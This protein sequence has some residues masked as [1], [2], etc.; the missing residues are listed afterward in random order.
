MKDDGKPKKNQTTKQLVMDSKY[1]FLFFFLIM[2]DSVF[3]SGGDVVDIIHHQI[4]T[5]LLVNVFFGVLRV[6]LVE[7]FVLNDKFQFIDPDLFSDDHGHEPTQSVPELV[8]NV[9]VDNVL[10][11]ITRKRR[12]ID[13]RNWKY[14]IIPIRTVNHWH[15]LVWSR[16]RNTY[17]HYDSNHIQRESLN[18]GAAKRAM[19]WMTM[20]FRQN[21]VTVFHDEPTL[22]QFKNYPQETNSKMDGGLYIFHGISSFV[23]YMHIEDGI[24]NNS[25][26]DSMMTWK[27]SEVPRIRNNMFRRL[28][29]RL[30]FTPWHTKLANYKEKY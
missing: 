25:S 13:K 7:K 29:E 30:E 2:D 24:F 15:F 10:R 20:W 1:R 19:K 18:L 6:E 12:G 27:K 21:F 28:A 17:T 14:F 22:V 16:V 23:D 4:Y 26:L 9:E 5:N 11:M 3:C 8:S